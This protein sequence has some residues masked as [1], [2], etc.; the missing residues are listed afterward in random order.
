MEGLTSPAKEVSIGSGSTIHRSAWKRN[1]RNFAITEFYEVRHE[2]WPPGI[3]P[4]PPRS[5]SSPTDARPQAL[6]AMLSLRFFPRQLLTRLL[7]RPLFLLRLRL[8]SPD[9]GV[10]NG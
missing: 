10:E 5:K 8:W 6:S 7:L 1:S 4:S 9:S 3:Q 2:K